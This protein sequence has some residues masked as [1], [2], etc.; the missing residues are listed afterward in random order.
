MLNFTY[1]LNGK[2][3]SYLVGKAHKYEAFSGLP[4][5]KNKPES[6]CVPDKGPI[7]KGVYYI[8]DRESGGKLGW[9]RDLYNGKD[10]WFALYKNDSLVDDFAFCDKIKRGQFRLHP[11]G[12]LGISKGC[13]TLKNKVKFGELRKRLLLTK[14][15]LIPKTTIKAYGMVTVS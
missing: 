2:E 3:I 1:K 12:P 15:E 4:G 11:E 6:V 14:S 8:V 13:I 5:Y 7:S 10:E 9:L